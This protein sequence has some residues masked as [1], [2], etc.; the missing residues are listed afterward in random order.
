MSKLPN[1]KLYR[2]CPK[3]HF[4]ASGKHDA[5]CP[6][7]GSKL[8]DSEEQVAGIRDYAK[9]LLILYLTNNP[10]EA[11]DVHINE[12]PA[13]ATG[14][15]RDKGIAVPNQIVTRH[16]LAECWD[17][18]EPVLDDYLLDYRTGDFAGFIIED[19]HAYSISWHAEAEWQAIIEDLDVCE[20]HLNH[21][22]IA[23]AIDRLKSR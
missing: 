21:K 20:D 3:C 1:I 13:Y 7:C 18:V 9:S 22:T 15:I 2:E 12:I 4:L 14:K 8:N 11:K 6:L 17:E 16:I 10:K 23:K 19:L 5:Y